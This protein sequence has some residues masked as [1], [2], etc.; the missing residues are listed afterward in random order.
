MGHVA[1]VTANKRAAHAHPRRPHGLFN[2]E[3]IDDEDAALPKAIYTIPVLTIDV[4]L[5]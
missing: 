3:F 4:F 5:F 2:L 1:S